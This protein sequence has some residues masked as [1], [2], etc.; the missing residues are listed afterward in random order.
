MQYAPEQRDLVILRV[1]AKG[2]RANGKSLILELIDY[3]DMNTG[4]MAMN[5]TVGFPASIAAQ[6]VATGAIAG[7][8][9]LSPIR[10]VPW[11]PF[12]GELADRGIEIVESAT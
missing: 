10:D 4:L 9:V 8:G 2:E 11:A 1:E 5:R 12:V 6:M 7:R 3:R